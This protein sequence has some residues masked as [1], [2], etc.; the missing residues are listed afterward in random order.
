MDFGETEISAKGKISYLYKPKNI[1]LEINIKNDKA[2]L[3]HFFNI[4]TKQNTLSQ[5]QMRLT[6]FMI[7]KMIRLLKKNDEKSTKH[8]LHLTVQKTDIMPDYVV[9]DISF[10]DLRNKII[11]LIFV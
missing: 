2:L 10:A 5:Q 1:N 11:K 9:N 6:R 4:L 7:K 3:D 8:D